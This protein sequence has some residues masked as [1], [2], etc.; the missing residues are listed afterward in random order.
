MFMG[1]L[2]S[3]RF[4]DGIPKASQ[5]T[6][7]TTLATSAASN[8]TT[9]S[10]AHRCKPWNCDLAGAARVWWQFGGSGLRVQECISGDLQKDGPRTASNFQDC[11]VPFRFY[12][13]TTLMLEVM[14]PTIVKQATIQCK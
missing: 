1:S 14:I 12:I 7:V 6:T 2:G 3:L 8:L 11:E 5:A 10:K 13:G 4:A 9:V